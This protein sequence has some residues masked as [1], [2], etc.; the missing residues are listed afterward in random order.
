MGGTIS[1]GPRIPRKLAEDLIHQ[2][3]DAAL[4]IHFTKCRN[5]GSYRRGEPDLGDL[6]V[7]GALKHDVTPEQLRT[8]CKNFGMTLHLEG[9]ERI[10]GVY[11]MK[12]QAWSSDFIYDIPI[13]VD[14][15]LT[16][17]QHYG[18]ALLYFTGSKEFNVKMRGYAKSRGFLLNQKG[19]W[20]R[21]VDSGKEAET[22]HAGLVA[23][24]TE[25]DIFKA[26]GIVWVP[27]EKRTADVKLEEYG[28]QNAPDPHRYDY[29]INSDS[30]A[31]KQY[32]VMVWDDS[33]VEYCTCTCPHYIYRL[34][35]SGGYCNHI[36][37]ALGTKHPAL[38]A[39]RK[40]S[41]KAWADQQKLG[42][43]LEETQ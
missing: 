26:L 21:G 7:V 27:P 38:K 20:E 34:A 13:Q 42:H 17:E 10:T 14:F 12:R 15:V 32:D 3:D 24:K 29:K 36:K 43:N 39:E 2:M 6:E 37:T 35:Q 11:T 31:G 5:A 19:L 33:T 1:K 28:A 16:T 22:R 40:M 8:W 18:A 4:G 25:E 23:S 30:E 9:D 41:A